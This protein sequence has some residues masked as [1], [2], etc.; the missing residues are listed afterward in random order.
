[1]FNKEKFKVSIQYEILLFPALLGFFIFFLWPAIQ[2]VTYSFTDYSVYKKHFSFIGLVNYF[3]VFKDD[4]L[5][6]A[7]SNTIIFAFAV[8]LFQNVLAIPLAV[9]LN[10]KLM[11]KN[12]LR[13]IFFIPWCF[14][15]LI[16]GFLWSF[17]LSSSDS[18][19]LNYI[20]HG[21][22]ID[23]L[24]HNWLGDPSLALK[25]AIGVAVWQTTGW[26]MIIYLAN[27]QSIPAEIY[28]S[29]KMDGATKLQTFWYITIRFL[30]PSMTINVLL[31]VIGG[32]KVYDQI[33][34]LTGGG[35]GYATETI[36]SSIINY[37]FVENRFGYA[38]SLSVMM[39]IVIMVISM[40]LLKYLSKREESLS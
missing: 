39:L 21:L 36:T 1:M 31:S 29:V 30:A 28:E 22:G 8:T 20:L 32:L 15:S 23:F 12:I 11:T 13:M 19:L 10:A 2:S 24:P 40:I 35:P 4:R 33:L 27:L 18:G 37:G 26:A 5:V 14:S 6:A 17:I 16:I 7:M 3:D 25:S 9:A 34:A 38:S